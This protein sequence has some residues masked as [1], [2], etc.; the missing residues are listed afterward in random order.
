MN[1]KEIFS[2]DVL[3]DDFGFDITVESKQRKHAR[4]RQGVWVTMN[5]NGYSHMR[6]SRLF[7]CTRQN[8]SKGIETFE[9]KRLDRE[10]LALE[11]SLILEKYW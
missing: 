8:I 1:K 7:N 6:I 5:C 4:A 10:P 2:L 9:S 11:Y 3:N